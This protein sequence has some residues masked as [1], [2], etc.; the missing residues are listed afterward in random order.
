M[1]YTNFIKST[2]QS[3]KYF[4]VSFSILFLISFCVIFVYEKKVREIHIEELKS[5]EKH[6]VS[7]Q[8]DL[9]SKELSGIQDDLHYLQYA[10]T[11]ELIKE[12]YTEVANHWLIFSTNRHIYDQI[13]FI[14]YNGDEQVRIN[15]NKKDSYIVPTSSLQ[16]KKNRYYFYKTTELDKGNVYISPLDLNIEHG[17]IE[18]PYKP[19]IRF[20]T[21]IYDKTNE[22]KGVI[23]LNY[24]AKSFIDNFRQLSKN[25]HG[26]VMLLNSEGYWLSSSNKDLEWNFMFDHRKHITF[27]TQ[28]K[29]EWSSIN[30]GSGQI[31]SSKG[32]FTFEPVQLKC[33]FSDEYHNDAYTLGDDNWYIVSIIAREGINDSFF[34]DNMLNLV[35]YVLKK[36]IIYFIFLI[37]IS[38][39]ISS[40]IHINKK[41]YSKIKFYSEYD[42]LTK[43]YN[44][45]AGISKLCHV[46]QENTCICFID[47]NGL[48]QVNDTLGHKSGD[49][50]IINAINIIKSNIRKDD[51]IIRFGGD[52]FIIVF[53]NMT[54]KQAENKWSYIVDCYNEFNEKS[55]KPYIISVSHGIASVNTLKKLQIDD[56]IKIAD[57]KMYK[58]KHIIKQS[59]HVIR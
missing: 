16:N 4:I 37:I 55:K 1:K 49:D 40:L 28:Y 31:I 14:N 22:L 53:N 21:P 48:K 38:T 9:I 36:N 43:V 11:D 46:S 25:S 12:N 32:L 30:K 20:S 18:V 47:I 39:I 52:E 13:R 24:L 2:N 17:E 45:R 6:L 19:M 8:K 57:E 34:T 50:L 42:S 10:F 44:R 23:V 33:N 35:F 59:L 29:N 3:I 54:T 51:F 5:S 41:T 27:K 58:E 15:V 7:L 26:D 56:F